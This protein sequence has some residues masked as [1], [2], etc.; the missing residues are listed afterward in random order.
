MG[1]IHEN[2]L[3]RPDRKKQNTHFLLASFGGVFLGEVYL[4]GMMNGATTTLLSLSLSLCLCLCLSIYLSLSLSL[5]LSVCG[6][7]RGPAKALC[8]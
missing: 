6:G 3:R 1:A 7:G 4:T 8:Y 2:L 5:S